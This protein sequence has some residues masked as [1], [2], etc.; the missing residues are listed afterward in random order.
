MDS[1]ST[2]HQVL[3]NMLTIFTVRSVVDYSFLKQFYAH[4]VAN[5]YTLSQRKSM[6]LHMINKCKDPAV[7]QVPQPQ[8][9]QYQ[10]QTLNPKIQS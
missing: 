4:E 2:S 10:R 7:P 9:L 1:N 5:G 6:I 3:F 8:T